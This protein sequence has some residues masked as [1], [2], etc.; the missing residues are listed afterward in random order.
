MPRSMVEPE[1][2]WLRKIEES[3]EGLTAILRIRWDVH[4]VEVE[5]M[6]GEGHSEYEYEEQEITE[7][8]PSSVDSK[9]ALADYI[10]KN[11]DKLLDTARKEAE[12]VVEKKTKTEE[13]QVEKPP[14]W[15][16]RIEELRGILP[17]ANERLK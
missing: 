11:K 7:K 3:S 1:T 17:N 10:S 9:K 4:T 5:D 14:Q 8:L 2:V 13:K 12:K 15:H 16:E 6:D